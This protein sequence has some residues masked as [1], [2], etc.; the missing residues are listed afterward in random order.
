MQSLQQN[1]ERQK[2]TEFE[3]SGET[4]A[5]EQRVMDM[6]QPYFVL[7]CGCGCCRLNCRAPGE[8]SVAAVS[9]LHPDWSDPWLRN[10]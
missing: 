3:W 1:M 5:F 10:Q 2:I 8:V 9:N 6:N 7:S 4:N